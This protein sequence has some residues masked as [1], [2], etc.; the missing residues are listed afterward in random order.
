MPESLHSWRDADAKCPF[1]QGDTRRVIHCEGL[2]VG[3]HFRRIFQSD[4]SCNTVFLSC[5]ARNYENCPIF[6]LVYGTYSDGKKR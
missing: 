4:A 1:Y 5:C 6:Q 2:V 3:E